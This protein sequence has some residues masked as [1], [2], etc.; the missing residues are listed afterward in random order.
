[1]KAII[2][3]IFRSV[4]FGSESALQGSNQ[5]QM[6]VGEQLRMHA[7]SFRDAGFSSNAAKLYE[8][9]LLYLPDRN[10]LLV[11]LGNMLKDSGEWERA[12]EVYLR[13][14]QQAPED[15]DIYLQ[16]GHVLKLSGKLPE[17]LTAY[18]R[19]L[20]IQPSS[21]AAVEVERLSR[22]PASVQHGRQSR[23][24]HGHGAERSGL[25][26]VRHLG[27]EADTRALLLRDGLFD[28]EW[29]LKQY[30]DVAAAGLDPIEHYLNTGEK[31]G[32][33]PNS[34][35][36][37]SDYLE[38]NLDVKRVDLGALQHY[39]IYGREEG[40]VL[41]PKRESLDLPDTFHITCQRPSSKKRVAV[42]VHVYY[43]DVWSEIEEALQNI[44]EEFDLYVTLVKGASD[45]L[46]E[47]ITA[48]HSSAC[49]LVFQ[50]HGR[51]IFPFVY[52][53][54][55]GVLGGYDA[56]CKLHTKRSLH[57]GD[58]DAWRQHLVQSLI[59]S[60]DIVAR[61]LAAFRSDLDVGLVAA[62][63]NVFGSEYWGTNAFHIDRLASKL[64]FT[65]DPKKITFAAGSMFWIHPFL[66]TLLS[67]LRLSSAD[68]EDELG[69]TDSTMAHAIERFFG[70]LA[71]HAGFRIVDAG[72]VGVSITAARP[73]SRTKVLAF[74]L[75]QYHPIPENDRWW[76]RG[77]TEWTNVTKAKP[78]FEGH[79]QPRLPTDLGFYDLRSDEARE[80]QA[81]LANEYGISAFCYYFYWFNGRRLLERPLDEMLRS[82]KPSFPFLLC[83]ANENWT[84]SWD[85]LNKDV[86]I[87]Q[88][89]SP[90][91]IELF[92][93]DV[94]PYFRDDRYFRHNG[95]PV[96]VVYRLT[97]I[98][99]Y[100][101]AVGVWRRKW[102]DAGV[103]HVHICAVKFHTHDLPE[104][105][106]D[107][108]V[109][110]YV[111]FPPHGVKAT[112]L[113]SALTNLTSDFDGFVY[114]Y[115]EVV[116]NN[117][118]QHEERSSFSVH[119]GLMLG[120]DNTARRGKGA[121]IAHG[122]TPAKF[123]Y[124]LRSAMLQAERHDPGA[125]HLIFVNAWNEWAEG[126]YL[127]PD[128]H[129]GRGYLEA[130]RSCI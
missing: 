84:R 15:A 112:R 11:Q 26:G 68:F 102:R 115:G 31:E 70:I 32:R 76:G 105:P 20:Q 123:R 58:G 37:A 65:Y 103:E 7:D 62:A 126:T 88:E 60:E 46:K 22:V 73:R 100:R 25:S 29:Y 36:R 98:P 30:P 1:M 117:L 61:I 12:E 8:A 89:H 125:D 106:S 113:N 128:V 107:A 104:S 120:W 41:A 90:S 3:R 13:A 80:A 121:H 99:N 38:A 56:V 77:F 78:L 87:R 92:A 74:Y 17:A 34:W 44:P 82:G 81:S 42:V 5:L 24:A 116:E 95:A 16:L 85:G 96:L 108:G 86:L 64:N 127:E 10:D 97:D 21:P 39:A 119:R 124:W 28:I 67:S 52:L 2:K 9:C 110:A 45:Q 35:F 18:Q 47:S 33:S 54:N 111:E 75:P 27:S 114:D 6:P 55:T 63:G 93:N 94:L 118:A 109:D 19:A 4:F 130:L 122:A 59:G 53:C 23:S 43:P 91:S 49:V 57:R 72:N 83:W 51:D 40:R 66:L 48:A 101:D 50:N 14:L 79:R 71:Q 129:F 69:Q